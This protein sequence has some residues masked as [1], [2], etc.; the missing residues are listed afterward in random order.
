MHAL[1][2]GYGSIGKRHARILS[3]QLGFDVE[4]VTRVTDCAYPHHL[5]LAAAGDLRRFD[6]FVIATETNRHYQNLYELNEAVSDR[7][8]LVEKPLFF[9]ESD[10]TGIRNRIFVG[11]NLRFHP[12]LQKTRELLQGRKASAVNVHVGEY[13][14][15][16]RSGTDY[17]TC[18]SARRS[19]GGGVVFDI[20]HE[21]DYIQWLFGAMTKLVS[22]T[23]RL[24]DLEI[25]SDDYSAVIGLTE[26]KTAINLSMDYLSMVPVR[27]ML[28]SAKD[29]SVLL[30]LEHGILSC[31]DENRNK[32]TWDFSVVERDHT[33][34]AMHRAIL[35]QQGKDACTLQEGLAT[36][37]TIQRIY[38]NNL[39]EKWIEA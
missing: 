31:C 18:Y 7:I 10:F 36:M 6:Y 14:P 27:S 16:W 23:G 32:Q 26:R 38:S 37:Q 11:Y 39:K 15:W 33:Y 21:I 28:A 35:E 9:K 17:R 34:R 22:L 19:E 20:S 5:S 1:V 12:A 4:V 24:S 25:D 29:A 13:L 3:E 8:I 2:I 30:D